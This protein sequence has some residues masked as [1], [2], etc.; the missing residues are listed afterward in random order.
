[1]REKGGD[2]VWG[3]YGF[4]DAFNP[5]TGWAAEDVIAIDN[6]IMLVMAENLQ[7]GFV[8]QNFMDAPEVKRGMQLAGFSSKNE[9]NAVAARV[10]AARAPAAGE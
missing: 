1:M 8:W 2:A 9:Q 7:S 3:K 10:P 5:Q 4:V 6:G